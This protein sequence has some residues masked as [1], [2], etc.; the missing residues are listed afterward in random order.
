MG[1][2]LNEKQLNY[3]KGLVGWSECEEIDFKTFCGIGALCERLLAHEFCPQVPSKKL[4]PCHE[5]RNK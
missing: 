4:D 2:P 5:V 3:F 1:K